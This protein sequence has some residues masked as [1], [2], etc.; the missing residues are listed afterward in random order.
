MSAHQD[1]KHNDDT[2]GGQSVEDQGQAF[3][4]EEDGG[5][6][7]EDQG[8]AFEDEDDIQ[9]VSGVEELNSSNE[10][11]TYAELTPV[12][13]FYLGE[14]DEECSQGR[15]EVKEKLA[16]FDKIFIAIVP[17][18]G[19]FHLDNIDIEEDFASTSN[20][21]SSADYSSSEIEQPRYKPKIHMFIKSQTLIFII[22][23]P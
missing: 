2:D 1:S 12:Q 22:F 23:I 10:E 6:Y 17:R 7:G 18:R 11:L 4:A 3:E 14:S 20:K 8:Q 13:S 5:Q 9:I 19:Y 21:P 15:D 16:L